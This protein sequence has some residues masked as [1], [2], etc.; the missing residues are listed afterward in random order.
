MP[1]DHE[2][3]VSVLYMCPAFV[4]RLACILLPFAVHS[5]TSMGR[6]KGSGTSEITMKDVPLHEE[7]KSFAEQLCKFLPSLE[8]TYEMASGHEHSCCV[9]LVSGS[10][11]RCERMKRRSQQIHTDVLHALQ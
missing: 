4:Q 8:C 1:F 10:G 3:A 5:A 6:G 9:V 7:V 2:V 11:A